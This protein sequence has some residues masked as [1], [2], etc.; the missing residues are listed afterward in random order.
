MNQ[1]K[2][3]MTIQMMNQTMKI[4]KKKANQLMKTYL[5]RIKYKNQAL[6]ATKPYLPC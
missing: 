6:K 4:Q 5:S 1:I 2:I 3:S